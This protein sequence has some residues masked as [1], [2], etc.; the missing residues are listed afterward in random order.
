MLTAHLLERQGNNDDGKESGYSVTDV[1]PV[2]L[3]DADGGTNRSTSAR[4]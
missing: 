2:D 1:I 3:A 4:C